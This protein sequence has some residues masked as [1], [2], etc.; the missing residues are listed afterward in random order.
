MLVTRAGIQWQAG[1]FAVI[2]GITDFL[3]S[4]FIDKSLLFLAYPV[5]TV[6][7]CSRVVPVMTC[8]S[9]INGERNGL[10]D[11]AFAILIC[12]GVIGFTFFSRSDSSAPKPG[13][14]IGIILI[15]AGLV[16]D[17][18][19]LTTERWVFRKNTGFGHMQMLF[20]TSL[21]GGVIGLIVCAFAGYTI[22]F[23]FILQN[24]TALGHMF[25]L[26][27]GATLGLYFMFY[28]VDHHGP[29]TVAIA[30]LVK[31]LLAIYLS[32]ILYHHTVTAA[33]SACALLTFGAVVAKTV[34]KYFFDPEVAVPLR[35]G[36]IRKKLN[37]TTEIRK[38]LGHKLEM[39]ATVLI[40][41]ARLEATLFKDKQKVTSDEDSQVHECKVAF[42]MI[43][44]DGSGSIDRDELGKVLK[45]LGSSCSEDDAKA[46][47]SENDGEGDSITFAQFFTLF[48]RLRHRQ[49][50][51]DLLEAFQ[52]FDEDGNGSISK[53]ELLDIFT[54]LGEK[55]SAEDVNKMIEEVD[56][57]HDGNIDYSEFVKMMQD[58]P[59]SG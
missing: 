11:Y 36:G 49:R 22:F 25:M 16:A 20:V 19:T 56:L 42:G 4:I 12:A 28:L 55:V 41:A 46:I 48:Q 50:E 32:A 54:N 31:Q 29:V 26:G 21:V 2:P 9:I 27:F 8:N 35:V 15:T 33:A 23:H 30:L 7:K 39:S 34:S 52:V 38:R 1:K 24:P 51:E 10:R 18:L 6:F 58:G 5:V 44:K 3:G 13:M 17:A 47:C 14:S 59:T 53:D 37:L 43:D 45:A 40:A 57:D